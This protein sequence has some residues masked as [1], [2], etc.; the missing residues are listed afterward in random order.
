M[1]TSVTPEPTNRPNAYPWWLALVE[2]GLIFLLFFLYVT[3]STPWTNE[4]HY[5]GKA[6]HFWDSTWCPGDYFLGSADAHFVFYWT[7]GWLTRWFSLPAVAWI[8][9]VVT[10]LLL[11][12]GWRRLSFTVV[13]QRLVAVLSA[14]LFLFFMNQCQMAGEWLIGG[15]EAKGFA[16]VFVLF[17]L[18]EII[19]NRWNRVWILLGVASSFHVL[20]GGW[21]VIAAGVSW[22]L[23]DRGG[24]DR[25]TS[26]VRMLP[27]LG[28]GMLLALP[29]LVPALMLNRGV[30]ASVVQ[31][32]KMIYVFERL[33]HHL[34]WQAFPPRL[35]KRFLALLVG[36]MLLY[37]WVAPANRRLQHVVLGALLIAVGGV[38]IEF[39]LVSLWHNHALAASLLRFYWY[40]MADVMLPLGVSL[41]I[42]ESIARLKEWRPVWG[43][44]AT[45]AAI[46]I[47]M[48]NLHLALPDPWTKGYYTL[49]VQTRRE[50]DCDWKNACRWISENTP[51]DARFLT[52]RFQQTF[53]WYAGRSEVFTRK[54]IPQDAEGVME[55]HQRRRDIFA[56][57]DDMPGTYSRHGLANL[58]VEEMFALAHKYNFQYV[59]LDRIEVGITGQLPP[60][61]QIVYPDTFHPNKSY[62]VLRLV[63]QEPD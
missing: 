61:L 59:L 35:V 55:W 16:Y 34:T 41:A 30:D 27:A 42:V 4:A 48:Q 40:R 32:A 28:M 23:G 22:L 15:V 56:T 21:S 51:P 57:A 47:A 25:K 58:S 46:L 18:T 44:W 53:K 2:V 63:K 12:W 54:D 19:R 33:P 17:A 36:W 49:E 31:E 45:V 8:G 62:V 43:Q 10:W 52:P 24:D 50:K 9:R 11:A 6:K 38:L 13:P 39:G 5:L 37:R 26:L 3:P 14:G 20:V 1:T 60:S 7:F 29:G